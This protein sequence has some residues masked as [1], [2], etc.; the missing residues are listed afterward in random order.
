MS[1]DLITRL[2]EAGTPAALVAEV[3]AALARA[4][5]TAEAK[6]EAA[7][8]P[9]A[10]AI[11]TRRWRHKASQNVTCDVGDAQVTKNVTVSAPSP[12]SPSSPHTPQKPLPPHPHP[13]ES[14]AYTRKAA[15]L[16]L[17]II[18]AGCAAVI[19]AK[20]ARAGG[21]P[22]DMPPPES[23]SDQ[24]WS[25][26]IAHRKAKK[27]PMTPRAYDLLCSKLKAHSCDEWPP[28]RIIDTIID[29]AWL[30][31]ERPWLDRIQEPRNGSRQIAD[32]RGRRG[33]RPDPSVDLYNASR[34]AEGAECSAS[35]REDSE[36]AWLS[37]P[38]IGTG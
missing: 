31:F 9:S 5:A 20:R 14:A 27:E 26:F 38:P 21:W 30:S 6:I 34:A 3:A 2:I 37:L 29:R 10:G 18:V 36:R 33:T 22:A 28:G 32:A 25:G 15:E 4:E 13:E 7:L 1:V 16:A 23:V 8:A 19:A 17:A 11:R 12:P 24:Q 35:H